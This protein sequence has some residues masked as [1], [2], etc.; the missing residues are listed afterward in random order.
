VRQALNNNKPLSLLIMDVDHFKNVND[1]YGHDIGDQLLKQIA[2]STVKTVRSADLAARFG[3]EEFVVLM[4][5]TDMQQA[6]DAAE[7]IRK[8]IEKTPM[9]VTHE[10]AQLSKT[11]SIGVAF[12]NDMGDSGAALIK[13]A[14]SALYQAKN[15]GR[16][17]VVSS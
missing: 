10:I 5:E 9:K 4:P 17:K 14:D 12:L 2:D 7:R 1:T 8:T 3:G 15:T 16:N 11:I 13:R 6:S